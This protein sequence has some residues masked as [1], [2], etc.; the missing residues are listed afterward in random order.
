[1]SQIQDGSS[2]RPIS[3]ILIPPG[4]FIMGTDIESFYGT[5][6]ERSKH[7]KLDES[8]I[9]AVTLAPY[10]IDRYPVTNVE[11]ERFTQST[12]YPPP[13]HWNSARLRHEEAHLPVVGVNWHDATAYAQ[14]AGKRLPTEA[15]WEKAARGV[16]GRMYP[17]G[18]DFESSNPADETASVEGNAKDSLI[19]Q[20]LTDHPTP[21]GRRPRVSSPYGADD[22]AGNVW[23]WTA[24]WYRPYN[25]NRQRG[26]DYGAKQKVLRG[27]SW[28]EVRDYTAEQYFRCANRLNAP[29]DYTANN[30]G[31]RCAQDVTP[32]EVP[33]NTPQ[34]SSELISKYIRQQKLKN[35]Y[36][37]KARARRNSIQ[38]FVIAAVL[39]GGA[40]YGIATTEYALAGLT[41]GLIGLGFLFSAGVNLWRQLK[42]RHRLNQLKPS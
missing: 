40:W 7:A 8:P 24:D 2:A 42:V 10:Y 22:M 35:L 31:F 1:M 29:Q 16:D 33:R 9:H 4:A 17:W 28:L 15:E 32:E 11:Y 25:G 23:E 39:I 41:G 6:L 37:V 18:D 19:T 26:R 20:L 14:W 21:V 34:I 13:A 12:E 30:I 36:I 5:A 38:D 27:G 3:T